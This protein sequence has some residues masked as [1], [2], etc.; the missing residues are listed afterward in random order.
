[1]SDFSDDA[2]LRFLSEKL[3]CVTGIQ[4]DGPKDRPGKPHRFCFSGTFMSFGNDLV[5]SA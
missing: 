1:M 5:L 2:F 3:V 4:Y